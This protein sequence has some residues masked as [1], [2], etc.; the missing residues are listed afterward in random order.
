MLDSHKN[1]LIFVQFPDKVLNFTPLRFRNK[2]AD[3]PRFFG[4]FVFRHSVILL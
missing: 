3:I 4:A 2:T 1:N